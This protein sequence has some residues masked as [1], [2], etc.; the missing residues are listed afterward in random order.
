MSV[1]DFVSVPD[2]VSV[3]NLL[4]VPDLISVPHLVSI[5]DLAS[6][7]LG[8]RLCVAIPTDA[9]NVE[10]CWTKAT[11]V[12]NTSEIIADSNEI[13]FVQ[14]VVAMAFQQGVTKVMNVSNA[15]TLLD[16]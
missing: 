15:S 9:V 13:S 5:A 10:R 1:P 2:L 4:S 11:G 14:I 8:L 3:P 6:R 7:L 16:H 12:Q